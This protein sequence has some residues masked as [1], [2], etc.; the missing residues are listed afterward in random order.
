LSGNEL[1]DIKFSFHEVPMLQKP[2]HLKE[3]LH[4][5]EEWVLTSS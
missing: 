1:E 3:L 4:I 2:F 5:I